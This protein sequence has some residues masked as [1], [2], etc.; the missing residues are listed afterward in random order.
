MPAGGTGFST[1]IAYQSSTSTAY[2]QGSG[3]VARWGDYSS[4]IADPNNPSGFWISN[5][6][7]TGASSWATALDEVTLGTGTQVLAF[8]AAT[9]TGTTGAGS[10]TT[11]MAAPSGDVPARGLSVAGFLQGL[12]FKD[13][14]RGPAGAALDLAAGGADKPGLDYSGSLTVPV[15]PTP[16]F[17]VIADLSRSAEGGGYG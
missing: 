14:F 8:Q 7:A 3:N 11:L 9:G 10:Q 2:T 12:G 13:L 17:S 6:Y 16:D 5:E 1:P 15:G 4:A